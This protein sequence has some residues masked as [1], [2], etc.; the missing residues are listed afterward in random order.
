MLDA[1]LGK[2]SLNPFLTGFAVNSVSRFY[3][4]PAAVQDQWL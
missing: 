2:T 1:K 4:D 3:S